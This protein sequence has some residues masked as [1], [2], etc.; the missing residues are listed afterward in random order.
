MS[1][2][3]NQPSRGTQRGVSK[4]STSRTGRSSGLEKTGSIGQVHGVSKNSTKRTGSADGTGP[5]GPAQGIGRGKGAGE[6]PNAS[7]IP[8]GVGREFPSA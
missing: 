3:K 8:D 1:L 6:A 2:T 5:V 7:G 4:N